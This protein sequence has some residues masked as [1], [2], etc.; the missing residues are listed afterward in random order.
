MILG[1]QC[2]T[3][4]SRQS[5]GSKTDPRQQS[6]GIEASLNNNQSYQRGSKTLQFLR[7]VLWSEIQHGDE[8]TIRRND[9]G[10]TSL[11]TTDRC[12]CS[13][14][15][16]SEAEVVI[17]IESLS[18]RNEEME[19]KVKE[20]SF[21]VF[22]GTSSCRGPFHH[23]ASKS[24]S[25][26]DCLLQMGMLFSFDLPLVAEQ[27]VVQ[28]WS[29]QLSGHVGIMTKSQSLWIERT[30]RVS[31]R[32][33]INSGRWEQ[34]NRHRCTGWKNRQSSWRN[35][36]FSMFTAFS[37]SLHS[38]DWPWRPFPMHAFL[39][40]FLSPSGLTVSAKN[41]SA[42]SPSL[43]EAIFSRISANVLLSSVSHQCWCL[44]RN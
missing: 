23:T 19:S 21:T 36:L 38:Q 10:P 43:P 13:I 2:L 9:E 7:V 12:V 4:G 26:S 35:F 3:R 16:T 24:W 5:H 42:M 8:Q 31:T 28:S 40:A 34:H 41:L 30:R 17:G 33:W 39:Q 27:D 29:N 44:L 15:M 20:E 14:P 1:K 11:T 18:F 6:R 22:V 37:A 32:E 25:F